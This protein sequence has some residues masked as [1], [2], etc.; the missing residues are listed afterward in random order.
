MT[1]E[2]IAGTNDFVLN[3]DIKKNKYGPYA[4]VQ[5]LPDFQRLRFQE[6]LP[7]FNT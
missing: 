4:T 3:L 6:Y 1:R 5:L 2:Q 7:E